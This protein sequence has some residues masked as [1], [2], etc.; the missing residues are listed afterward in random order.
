MKKIPN[1][2]FVISILCLLSINITPVIAQ[3]NTK[4]IKS[5][6]VAPETTFQNVINVAPVSIL[7]PTVVEIPIEET[8][9]LGSSILV[10]ESATGAYITSY[11]HQTYTEPKIPLT[12]GSVPSDVNTRKLSDGYY[13]DGVTY[14]VTEEGEGVVYLQVKTPQPITTSHLKLSLAPYVSL[15]K[16]IQIKARLNEISSMQTIIAKK[17]L[18]GTM[19]SFPEVTADYFEI[20][21][22]YIQPLRITEIDFVQKTQKDRERTIRFLAQPNSGYQIFYDSDQRINVRTMEG[23]DLRSD[24]GVLRLSD[25]VSVSNSQYV[26]ADT[27]DD[28]IP[29]LYDN[30]V[31]VYNPDQ[32]DID[33]N[34]RGDACDDWDRDGILNYMDNCPHHPNRNQLDT[35]GDGIGDVCDDE[36]SRFTEKNPWIPWVGMGTAAF[37]I[38]I[39]FA[40]VAKGTNEEDVVKNAGEDETNGVD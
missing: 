36:E 34:G 15:P 38:L 5:E 6:N 22:T 28:D 35:D 4:N 21:L 24:E 25:Y 3:S 32:A 23:G 2:I 26:M 29:D 17:S 11:L 12:V 16:S 14:Q 10:K 1:F 20:T 40:T 37:V 18:D 31:D 39:L 9:Y 27:D 33:G 19:I 13:D 8:V 30:C 7:V